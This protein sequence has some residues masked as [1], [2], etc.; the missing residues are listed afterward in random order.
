MVQLRTCDDLPVGFGLYCTRPPF[1]QRHSAL[2][3]VTSHFQH[4]QLHTGLSMASTRQPLSLACVH[5]QVGET[6]AVRAALSM[7]PF[8]AAVNLVAAAFLGD[9]ICCQQVDR[10]RHS[11]SL[12]VIWEVVHDSVLTGLV[13]NL[14]VSKSS[15]TYFSSCLG[16]RMT[17][18]IYTH[19]KTWSYSDSVSIY[20]KT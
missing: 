1:D 11:R 4:V 17:F 14:A 15:G 16:C 2:D 3:P 10:R 18:C 12:S 6:N 8:T 20:P 19:R 9:F 7:P 13:H 5:A